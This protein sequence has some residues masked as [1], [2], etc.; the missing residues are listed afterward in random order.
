MQKHKRPC[1]CGTTRLREQSSSSRAS[2]PNTDRQ[3]PAA[4][5][6]GWLLGGVWASECDSY[7]PCPPISPDQVA[8][9]TGLAVSLSIQFVG[10]GGR[11]ALG[12]PGCPASL[13]GLFPVYEREDGRR[14]SRKSG[15]SSPFYA[16]QSSVSCVLPPGCG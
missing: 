12:F 5:M 3:I 15:S 6:V 9:L 7:P 1:L 10:G 16:F 8:A 14:R 2:V 11:A 4:G 13:S